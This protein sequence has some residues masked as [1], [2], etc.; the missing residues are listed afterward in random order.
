[1]RPM[2]GSVGESRREDPYGPV[3]AWRVDGLERQLNRVE[4][5]A[6]R[7]VE[8]LENRLNRLFQSRIE[9]TLFLLFVFAV[10]FLIVVAAASHH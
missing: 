1:M 9:D 2:H 3:P 6:G 5:D 8:Q 10:V 7:R 4:R